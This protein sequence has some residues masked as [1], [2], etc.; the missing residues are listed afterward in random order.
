MTFT[1]AGT[2]NPRCRWNRPKQAVAAPRQRSKSIFSPRY[3]LAVVTSGNMNCQGGSRIR[4]L[5]SAGTTRT[6]RLENRCSMAL[7][8]TWPMRLRKTGSSYIG[9]S[10]YGGSES[11]ACRIAYADE[12]LHAVSPANG[13]DIG[14]PVFVA[15]HTYLVIADV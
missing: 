9:S 4:S 6:Y 1:H 7:A 2:P 10:S 15:E 14:P 13:L 8:I 11:C 3:D 12:Q 5:T